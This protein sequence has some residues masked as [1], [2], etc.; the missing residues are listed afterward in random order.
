MSAERGVD[1][2]SLAVVSG[3]ALRLMLTGKSCS[4]RVCVC[5]HLCQAQNLLKE[6]RRVQPG[7]EDLS[8]SSI[9]LV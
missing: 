4:V 2:L 9:Q 3:Y 5:V 1:I 7:R 8:V 6:S